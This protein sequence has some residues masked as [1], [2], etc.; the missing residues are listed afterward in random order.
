[1]RSK[2][3]HVSISHYKVIQV[4]SMKRFSCSQ[5]PSLWK[6]VNSNTNNACCWGEKESMEKR[7][8]VVFNRNQRRI[9]KWLA[10]LKENFSKQREEKM[11][12]VFSVLAYVIGTKAPFDLPVVLIEAFTF[13]CLTLSPPWFLFFNQQLEQKP[14]QLGNHI[15]QMPHNP[16]LI[17]H[18]TFAQKRKDCAL[19]CH[20]WK[21][22]IIWK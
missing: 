5:T 13:A 20:Q 21:E 18:L 9:V 2:Q 6:S 16:K 14:K 19:P 3:S 17:N 11:L 12:G 10:F 7:M 8:N 4:W 15:M 1:M 22:Y